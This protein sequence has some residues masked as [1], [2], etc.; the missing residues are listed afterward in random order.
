MLAHPRHS[1]S[2]DAGEDFFFHTEARPLVRMLLC[3]SLTLSTDA[4]WLGR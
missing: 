2:K 3:L 1:L 4:Q